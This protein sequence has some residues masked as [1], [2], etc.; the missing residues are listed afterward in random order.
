M[1][2]LRCC[3]CRLSQFNPVCE[4]DGRSTAQQ[5]IAFLHLYSVPSGVVLLQADIT[6]PAAQQPATQPASSHQLKSQPGRQQGAPGPGAAGIMQTAVPLEAEP[7]AQQDNLGWD[8]SRLGAGPMAEAQPVRASAGDD[9]LGLESG[10]GRRQRLRAQI[11]SVAAPVRASWPC[12]ASA[13]SPTA[14]QVS[15]NPEHL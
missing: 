2:S 12:A 4:H 13:P 5:V 6:D 3:P 1:P 9:W 11:S 7:E 14:A 10:T 15:S 8:S